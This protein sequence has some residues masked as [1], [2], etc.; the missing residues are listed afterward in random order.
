MF[1]TVILHLNAKY[2][3]FPMNIAKKYNQHEK[4]TLCDKYTKLYK[5][6][7]KKRHNYGLLT[8]QSLLF[9]LV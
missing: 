3:T 7:K 6:N 4:Y 5:L 1:I 9:D 2:K 8:K